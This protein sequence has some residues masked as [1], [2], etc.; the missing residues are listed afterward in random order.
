MGHILPDLPY[1]KSALAPY[2]SEETIE[3]HYGKHHNAYVTNLNKLIVG[4]E[5]ENAKLEDICA[6]AK[7]PIFNNAAQHWNHIM[8]WKCMI[9]GGSGEPSGKTGDLITKNFG[10]FAQFKEKFIATALTHFGSGWA[11]LVKKDDVL[12]IENTINAAMPFEDG[13]KPILACDIWEHS[14]Y[15]DYRNNRGAYLESFLKVVNWNHVESLV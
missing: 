14:Y 9:P 8:Y 10:S 4:T 13:K 11:W 15:I 2:I 12:T 5:F 1:S 7:G 3:F 6:K